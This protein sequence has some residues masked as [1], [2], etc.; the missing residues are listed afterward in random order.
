MKKIDISSGETLPG[1]ENLKAVPQEYIDNFNELLKSIN[2]NDRAIIEN[3]GRIYD[4][5]ADLNKNFISTFARCKKGCSACCKIDVH[6]TPLEAFFIEYNTNIPINT[7]PKV[8][9]NN[10]SPCPFLNSQ[11]A[12]SIY[13]YRPLLCRTYHVLSDPALCYQSSNF[14]MQYGL[15]S[16]NMSNYIYLNAFMWIKS[17]SEHIGKID[18]KDIRDIFDRDA[19]IRYN[20]Q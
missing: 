11:S 16:A 18:Y 15:T 19:V 4:F 7:N 6:L 17:I 2:K 1:H 13:D 10:K 8:T 9:F 3:L 12:C 20:R 5:I 14:V